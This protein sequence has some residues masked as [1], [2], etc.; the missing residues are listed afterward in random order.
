MSL[1]KLVKETK[2]AI[3]IVGRFT[4]EIVKNVSNV[5]GYNK[6][7]LLSEYPAYENIHKN[8]IDLSNKLKAIKDKYVDDEGKWIEIPEGKDKE[9]F[10]KIRGQ[11]QD[12]LDSA[13]LPRGI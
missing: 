5:Y 12:L 9:A 10:D 11:I 4:E 2:K 7:E 1:T 8:L 6:D 3:K 13:G